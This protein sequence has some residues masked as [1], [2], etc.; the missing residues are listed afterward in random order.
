MDFI[1]YVCNFA[2]GVV[3]PT[4]SDDAGVVVFAVFGLVV[5]LE[6]SVQCVRLHDLVYFLEDEHAVVVVV[7]DVFKEEAVHL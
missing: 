1:I 5:V 7:D 4:D 6:L 2:T 3:V